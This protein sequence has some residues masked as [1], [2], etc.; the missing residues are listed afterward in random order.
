MKLHCLGSSSHG[1]CYICESET[2]CLVL[3]AGVPFME[4][5]HKLNFEISRIQGMILSHPHGDHAKYTKEFLKAAIPCYTSAGTIEELNIKNP[6]L[7]PIQDRKTYII[8]EWT[9]MPF[10][11]K[12]DTKEPF[13]YLIKHPESGTFCFITD[14]SM[15][16][17]KFPA[18][19]HYLIECNFS[20]EILDNRTMN[21]NF[22]A[23]LRNRIINSHLS[24]EQCVEILKENDLSQVNNIVLLHL[25]DGNSDEQKF[26]ETLTGQ[27]GRKVKIADKNLT[28]NLNKYGI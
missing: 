21:G 19:N 24:L 14:T 13:G 28:L 4:V 20:Y 27:L 22:N 7:R 3:E 17:F 12:H 15:V 16:P 2:S 10:K 11:V 26:T 8:G 6:F 1:N 18:I 23:Q 5:K 25:S 9:I